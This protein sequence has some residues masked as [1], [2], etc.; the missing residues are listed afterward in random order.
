MQRVIKSP[1]LRV[2]LQMKS[3]SSVKSKWR[4]SYTSFRILKALGQFGETGPECPDFLRLAHFY[5]LTSGALNLLLICSCL[6]V[7]QNFRGGKS[8]LKY[9]LLFELWMYTSW[10]PPLREKCPYSGF[11]G[12]H[13]LAFELNTEEYGIFSR[14]YFLAFW[15][16]TDRYEVSLS[17]QSECGK[18][19]IKKTPN[20]DTFHAVPVL[21]ER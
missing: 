6:F 13:F 8:S 9:P 1:N 17:T 12:Q 10:E 15:L 5:F 4:S 2:L 20:T 19:R 11:S 16:N 14:P 18:I 7:P 3:Y 21:L